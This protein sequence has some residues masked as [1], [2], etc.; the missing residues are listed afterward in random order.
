MHQ[1]IKKQNHKTVLKIRKQNQATK[2]T[3]KVLQGIVDILGET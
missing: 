1:R 2:I 3:R